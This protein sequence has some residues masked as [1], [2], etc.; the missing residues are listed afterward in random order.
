[1]IM[2]LRWPELIDAFFGKDGLSDIEELYLS[3][4]MHYVAA[5]HE[6]N[7]CFGN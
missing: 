2:D 3:E 5:N 7:T 1:M 4:F 6:N